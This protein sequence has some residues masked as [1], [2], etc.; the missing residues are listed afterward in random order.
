MKDSCPGEMNFGVFGK[1]FGN[2]RVILSEKLIVW[3]KCGVLWW[4]VF[5]PVGGTLG[6]RLGFVVDGI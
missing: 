6:E 1:E 5:N 4:M 2:F 3:V